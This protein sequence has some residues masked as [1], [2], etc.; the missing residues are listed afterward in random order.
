M[1]DHGRYDDSPLIAEAYDH[2][3]PYR[4]RPDVGFYVEAAREAAGPVLELG[5]G[6]SRVLLPTARAGIEI[7]GLDSSA[8]M[9]AICRRRLQDEPRDVRA[10][11]SLHQG[12][13]QDFRLGQRF[14]L[15]TIP[16]RPFQHLIT[17][18]EQLACLRAI[19]DHL[20][21]GG[22]LVFDL[23]NPSLDML[24]SD[25]LGQELGD[26]PE[27]TLPDGSRLLRRYRIVSRDPFAQTNEVEMIY[28][29]TRPDGHQERRVHAFPM[30]YL[31]RYE[32]EHLLARAGFELEAI[33]ADFEKRPYGSSYPGD[34]VLVARR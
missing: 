17:V 14:G 5:C 30:R 10:R 1:I 22:R 24:T 21:P 27:V 13:M 25:D 7:V 23:F 11:V 32:A 31:F 8:H 20:E 4:D 6:T 28:Y 15:V 19:R 9:L 2:V 12:E 34:L 33:Y 26:E 16:F 3:A 29:V 18:R